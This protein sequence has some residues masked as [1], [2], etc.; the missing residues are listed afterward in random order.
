[1]RAAQSQACAPHQHARRKLVRVR[2]A[3]ACAPH[4][5]AR[6]TRMR[7]AHSQ[8]CAPHPHARHSLLR[9]RATPACAPHPHA[10][11]RLVF[12][13]VFVFEDMSNWFFKNFKSAILKNLGEVTH[14][15]MHYLSCNVWRLK[16]RCTRGITCRVIGQ[17]V[18][19]IYLHVILVAYCDPLQ[20]PMSHYL[21]KSCNLASNVSSFY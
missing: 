7:A 12:V 9:V 19:I 6:R 15:W 4:P 20:G 1:M 2:A 21:H 11:I 10:R 17:V 13:H 3:P 8:A 18:V 14:Y 16:S 5:H